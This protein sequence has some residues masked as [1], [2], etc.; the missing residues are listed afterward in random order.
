[1]SSEHK[2]HH[3]AHEH[4]AG[5]SKQEK[6]LGFELKTI[7]LV[8]V[9]VIVA[10][11]AGTWFGAMSTQSSVPVAT[12][13]DKALLKSNIE[14][15]FNENGLAIFGSSGISLSVLNITDANDGLLSVEFSISDGST[16]EKG[17]FLASGSRVYVAQTVF[18]LT[19]P[20]PKPAA[21]V[22][23][24]PTKSDKPV[25]DLYVM[26][27]CPY[28]NQAED[29]MLP[30]YNALKS[31]ADFRIHYIVSVD[32]NT[33][34]SLHGAKEVTENEKEACV[35]KEYGLDAWFS[36]AT[37]VNTNCGSTGACFADA[38]K[39][40]SVDTAKIDACVASDGVALMSAN[41]AASS[42][43]GANGSP[44]LIVNGV[45]SNSV[46]QYGNSEAYKTAI[47]SA[48][49]TAPSECSIQLSAQ[50]SSASAGGA[51]APAQ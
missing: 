49:N 18:D 46:Y 20:L 3:S 44:T 38:A 48:F 32:G 2:E 35:L 19:T 37:Y 42:A 6:I 45:K 8:F 17:K 13:V 39:A 9:L 16:A 47:C 5:H 14:N 29:T 43:A 34:Q 27:F 4:S 30:V 31:K 7:V 22:E 15:Y 25:V 40:A 26:S 1:M 23:A 36:V 12:S 10:A 51:C 11:L 50:T 28:G 21:P 24:Q 41:G 33:V